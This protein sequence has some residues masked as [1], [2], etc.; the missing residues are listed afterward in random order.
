MRA[1]LFLVLQFLLLWSQV[2]R[3]RQGKLGA[4]KGEVANSA[5]G[6]RVLGCDQLNERG[7]KGEAPPPYPLEIG[8]VVES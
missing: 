8:G 3:R 4:I 5:P 6:L 1:A 7:R 2:W